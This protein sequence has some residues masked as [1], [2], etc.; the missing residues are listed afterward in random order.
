MYRVLHI[1]TGEFVRE[2]A[3]TSYGD[4]DAFIY[5][6][7]FEAFPYE[8]SVL[9]RKFKYFARRR[10]KGLTTRYSLSISEFEIIDG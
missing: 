2:L 1:P 8:G 6:Q 3:M 9:T 10:I 4:L 5:L 7:P